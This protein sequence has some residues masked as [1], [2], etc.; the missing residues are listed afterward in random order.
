MRT[1]PVETAQSICKARMR[2]AF[3]A[4]NVKVTALVAS[5]GG[6]DALPAGF[7]ISTPRWHEAEAAIEKA[8]D[9]GDCAATEDAIADYQ[10]RV[11]KFCAYWEG[12]APLKE[13]A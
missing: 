4:M 9:A 1:A 12:K 3:Q 13:A 11:D 10:G 8:A 2:D 7:D 6:W 5:M